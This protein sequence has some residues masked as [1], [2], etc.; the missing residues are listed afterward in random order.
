MLN[1]SLASQQ[2]Y[3]RNNTRYTH[4]RAPFGSSRTG[5]RNSTFFAHCA[6]LKKPAR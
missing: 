4:C 1:Q 2:I 3:F 5:N 6:A